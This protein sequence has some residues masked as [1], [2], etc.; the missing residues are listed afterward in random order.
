MDVQEEIAI[1]IGH[2]DRFCDER[3]TE[4]NIKQ[5]CMSRG[6]PSAEYK[7]FFESELGH[8]AL[9]PVL[10]GYNGP[11]IVRAMLIT[12]LM[13]RAGAM[14]P[15]HEDMNAIALLSAMDEDVQHDIANQ[16]L[17]RDGRTLFS[18]AFSEGGVKSDSK[19]I[20]TE[21][22]ADS[23]GI[24]LDGE[25]TFVAN[26]QFA[27]NTLVLTQDTVYGTEDGGQSLWLV[28]I[29]APGVNT[30]PLNTVGQEMMAPA[31]IV[32]DHVQLDPSWRVQTNGKLKATLQRQYA[33]G[34]I[35]VCAASLGLAQAAMDDALERCATYKTRGSYLGSI[36][37]V[38][39]MI[40]DMA[41]KIRAMGGL[42]KRAAV[43]VSSDEPIEEQR[44]NCSLMKYYVPKTATEVASNAL[45]IFG[46]MGYTDQTRVSRI[47]RECRGNQLAQG[48]DEM[49]VRGISKYLLKD[50]AFTHKDM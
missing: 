24:F 31:G 39:E 6:V 14:L 48:A 34:R 3:I 23:D 27:P 30:Y 35:Y 47:W 46:G 38:Q 7:A 18:Q 43:S 22:T 19:G 17:A 37:Q 36:P 26:G 42:V 25:K 2:V 5:W 20:T 40:A 12:R 29:T 44:Y 41:A 1:A 21:V 32:F 11:F 8:Y 50:R 4:D 10:G 9:P 13:R 16:L 28:P 45:Q 49:M 15:F 33:L